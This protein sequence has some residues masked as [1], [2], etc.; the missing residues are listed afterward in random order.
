M[1]QAVGAVVNAGAG[2]YRPT[3]QNDLCKSWREEATKWCDETNKGKKPRGRNFNKRFYE[4]LENRNPNMFNQFDPEIPVGIQNAAGAVTPMHQLLAAGSTAANNVM[5][6]WCA[7]GLRYL[8]ATA[9]MP[10]TYTD[11]SG[12][13]Q[14]LKHKPISGK[15]MC[16]GLNS[17]IRGQ[18]GSGHTGVHADG[19][20][21]DGTNVEIK[22]PGDKEKPGQFQKEKDCAPNG[23]VLVIDHEA[24]DPNGDIT[25]PGGACKSA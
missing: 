1:P 6:S 20:L 17:R 5:L 3:E 10:T 7:L 14:K 21:R 9:G 15:G 12:V 11:F 13:T 18:F 16:S 19:Q 24:C 25:T 2:V 22:G 8:G 4:N 23:K